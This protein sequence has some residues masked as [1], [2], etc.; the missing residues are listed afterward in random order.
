M[1]HPVTPFIQAIE[2]AREMESAAKRNRLAAIK[3]F[4]MYAKWLMRENGID[5]GTLRRR[6]G[7]E[8]HKM[9]NF[10]HLDYCLT[11]NDMR[12]VILAISPPNPT[13]KKLVRGHTDR[14]KKN[15]HPDTL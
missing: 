9:G 4:A 10:L 14:R 7:W 15:P 1:N 8:Q 3:A 6:L 11:P 13:E 2:S 12:A 5:S